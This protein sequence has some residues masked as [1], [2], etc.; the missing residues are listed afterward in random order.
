MIIHRHDAVTSTNDLVKEMADKGA[1]QWT[2]VVARSQT[3]GRGRM[4]RSWHSPKGNL[5]VSVLL[6]QDILPSELPRLS[7]LISLAVF[8][9]L[10]RGKGPLNLKWPNDIL[11]DRRK[12]AGVL[13]EGRTRNDR[14]EYVVAGVGINLAMNQSELPEDLTDKIA[15][16]QEVDPELTV[17]EILVRLEKG[18]IKY[19]G[20]Y[21]GAPWTAARTDF[22]R[23]SS[24]EAG[25][26]APDGAGLLKGRPVDM[27]VDGWLVL[28]T[29][30]GL[31]TVRSDG[32]AGPSQ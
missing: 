32:L 4:G 27:T 6:K 9:A 1:P 22:L 30:E 2:T 12:I 25:Y 5:Y 26:R 15:F 3:E 20:S 28:D 23:L 7:I 16:L 10:D 24:R 13:L 29:G 11:L 19:G 14:V 17:D 31:V 18:L 8:M 21:R